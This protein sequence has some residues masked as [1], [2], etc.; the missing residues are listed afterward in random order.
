MYPSIFV[1]FA[2]KELFGEITTTP[3]IASSKRHARVSYCPI[4]TFIQIAPK[5]VYSEF[6]FNQS[7]GWGS[8]STDN[9]PICQPIC[10]EFRIGS[11]T[12][13]DLVRDRDAVDFSN[14]STGI[15]WV[16]FNLYHSSCQWYWLNGSELWLFKNNTCLSQL[17]G[18]ASLIHR[19]S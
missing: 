9:S 19:K 14:S 3:S 2:A 12:D 18:Q 6:A 17:S 1:C 11:R 8:Q 5:W 15:V 16:M 7:S 4:M 13:L 10:R